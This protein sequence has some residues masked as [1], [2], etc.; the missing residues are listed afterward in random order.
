MNYTIG[1]TGVH[2]IAN[3]AGLN[4]I[5][6]LKDV[7]DADIKTI[8]LDYN[9]LSSGFFTQVVDSVCANESILQY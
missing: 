7:A 9:P 4:V 6:S 5:R 2:S 3:T 8:A 1:V